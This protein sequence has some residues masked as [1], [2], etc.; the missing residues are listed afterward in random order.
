MHAT[1]IPT[2]ALTQTCN[3]RASCLVDNDFTRI[4][5]LAAAYRDMG[6]ARAAEVRVAVPGR[7][8]F[9]TESAYAC[10]RCVQADLAAQAAQEGSAPGEGPSAG[11]G[12]EKPTAQG[13][14]LNC[15]LLIGCRLRILWA[16]GM[17]YEGVVT[18]YVICLLAFELVCSNVVSFLWPPGYTPI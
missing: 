17:W 7:A 11:E 2:A 10:F 8:R 16:K 15:E 9:D 13:G 12:K 3:L 14:V 18:G 5:K 1:T 6:E 4:S